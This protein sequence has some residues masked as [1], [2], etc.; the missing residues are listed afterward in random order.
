MSLEA[1]C[2]FD[3]DHSCGPSIGAGQRTET[4][5]HIRAIWHLDEFVAQ[6]ARAVRRVHLF[7]ADLTVRRMA[8]VGD[9]FLVRNFIEDALH[10]ALHG[11]LLRAAQ[12]SAALAFARRWLRPPFAPPLVRH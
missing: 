1:P 5:S 7:H 11:M 3:R 6:N 8:I 2:G 12:V 9:G 10:A 4:R